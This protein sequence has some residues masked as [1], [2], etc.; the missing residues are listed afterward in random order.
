MCAHARAYVSQKDRES[1]CVCLLEK[2]HTISKTV[3]VHTLDVPTAAS[4]VCF[5][6]VRLFFFLFVLFCF[7][8]VRCNILCVF[9]K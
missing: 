4:S 7:D 6:F 5:L 2:L 8:F 1:E 9:V 3:L